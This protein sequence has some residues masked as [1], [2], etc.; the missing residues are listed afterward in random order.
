MVVTFGFGLIWK[1]EDTEEMHVLI[2]PTIPSPIE[3]ERSNLVFP[4][5]VQ[6]F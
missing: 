3:L 1:A 4:V 5:A 6:V 2:E